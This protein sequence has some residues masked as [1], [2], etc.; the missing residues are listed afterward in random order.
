MAADNDRD[1]LVNINN[2]TTDG[3][4]GGDRSLITNPVYAFVDSTVTEM[5]LPISTCYLFEQA[6]NLTYD[7]ATALYLVNDQHHDV[8]TKL[9]PNITLTLSPAPEYGK[10]VQI[11]LPYA[12]FDLTAKPPYRG[13]STNQ[14][15]FPLRR[16]INETQYTLGRVFLQEAYLTVDWER[17]NFYVSQ[18]NWQPVQTSHLVAIEPLH[19]NGSL[20]GRVRTPKSL[21]TGA[22]VGI[23]VA[24]IALGGIIITLSIL[25]YR[26]KK[27]SKREAAEAKQREIAAKNADD[28]GSGKDAA[29]TVAAPTVTTT[30]LA[31][32]AELDGSDDAQRK[33]FEKD[34][35]EHHQNI[36][37]SPVDGV[38]VQEAPPN[39]IFE[40]PGDVP[41]ESEADGRELSEKEA[42]RVR[43]ARY[44]GVEPPQPFKTP[45]PVP[46]YERIKPLGPLPPV[47][48]TLSPREKSA[49]QKARRHSLI[50][51]IPPPPHPPPRSALPPTPASPIDSE[52]SS[53]PKTPVKPSK[54]GSG[55]SRA[56]SASQQSPVSPVTPGTATTASGESHYERLDHFISP[57][58]ASESRSL[59]AELISA[60]AGPSRPPNWPSNMASGAPGEVERG[61]KTDFLTASD[62]KKPEKRS[63][64]SK[65]DLNTGKKRFSWED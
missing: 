50:G 27:R 30:G 25:L 14:R 56:A 53:S 61:K 16:A 46:R 36:G 32:K 44:N 6:F 4:T 48:K 11:T 45:P 62:G 8:L 54:M 10:T 1:I 37:A 40:L 58:S 39:A 41:M 21:E 51:P 57:V 7:N 3:V 65:V 24:I 33:V 42:M 26:S 19:P 55:R 49:L 20:S 5:W 13:V 9:N 12:A 18:I 43:E 47:I 22:I 60:R 59:A 17:Q 38:G 31:P 15:F 35:V 64:D 29:S 28:A 63:S 2:I 34:T 52:E 23:V